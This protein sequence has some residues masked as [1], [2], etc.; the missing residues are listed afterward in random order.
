[1]NLPAPETV[2]NGMRYA[3]GGHP[4][5][6]IERLSGW[7][8]GAATVAIAR[9]T[10]QPPLQVFRAVKSWRE[11][12]RRAVNNARAAEFIHQERGRGP[13]RTNEN[14][15]KTQ[16]NCFYE[17]VSGLGATFYL[18]L[19]CGRP[20]WTIDS[21]LDEHERTD[22]NEGDSRLFIGLGIGSAI[23]KHGASFYPE[24]RWPAGGN[25]ALSDDGRRLRARLHNENPW[26]WG[27]VKSACLHCK[28]DTWAQFT[29]KN[30]AFQRHGRRPPAP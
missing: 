26:L 20:R 24:A 2:V 25:V 15:C 21:R 6:Y 4:R 17:P 23:Y 11:R 18:E 12:F 30:E 19:C 1:M 13:Y 22:D 10:G 14:A 8:V 5:R 29:S 27:P 16:M 7:W 28:D 3:A 9:N